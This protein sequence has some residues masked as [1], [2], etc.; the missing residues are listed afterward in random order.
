MQP[1]YLV[2]HPQVQAYPGWHQPEKKAELERVLQEENCIVLK[3]DTNQIPEE[4]PKD[5]PI[6]V[7]GIYAEICVWEVWR[8]LKDKGYDACI[9]EP[10]S[11]NAPK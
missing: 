3:D 8:L 10:A 1:V 6:K 2:V 4:L 7:C 11:Y 9:Y 5:Q